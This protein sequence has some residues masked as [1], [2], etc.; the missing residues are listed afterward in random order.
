MSIKQD[1]IDA[2][3]QMAEEQRRMGDKAYDDWVQSQQ[4]TYYTMFKSETELEKHLAEVG[5]DFIRIRTDKFLYL[6]THVGIGDWDC[7]WWMLIDGEMETVVDTIVN[8]KY[9]PVFI[10]KVE[11]SLGSRY[12]FESITQKNQY[13]TSHKTKSIL[14]PTIESRPEYT[15][16]TIF[17][18]DNVLESA[19]KKMGIASQNISNN[20]EFVLEG[21]K[22][23]IYKG[24]NGNYVFKVSGNCNLEKIYKKFI[25]IETEY[26]KILQY[27]ICENIKN[28]VQ[29]NSNYSFEQEEF[30][31][32][33]SIVITVN[34]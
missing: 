5:Y 32:D 3:R 34:I 4:K 15:F 18:D 28:K 21:C 29:K 2:E 24:N 16:P 25:Q 7:I 31:E 8:N 17:T 12:F 10:E 33:G 30:L 22:T 26:N 20:F 6:K 13:K 14:E 27:K 11:K 23:I 1:L 19:L 9:M